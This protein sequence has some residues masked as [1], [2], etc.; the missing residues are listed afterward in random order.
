MMLKQ[1][2]CKAS[3][4]SNS[5]SIVDVDLI[6]LIKKDWWRNITYGEPLVKVRHILRQILLALQWM[7]EKGYGHLDI[8]RKLTWIM[9]CLTSEVAIYSW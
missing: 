2:I 7:H 1:L 6:A 3:L 4:F 5:F 9:K 8:K